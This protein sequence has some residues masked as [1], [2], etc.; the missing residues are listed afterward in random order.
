MSTTPG[1]STTSVSFNLGVRYDKNNG[2][3]SVGQTVIK[4]SAFSPRVSVT[5]DPTG[6]GAWT[7]SA[8]YGKY[9][10]AIANSVGDSQSPGG[11]PATYTY[12]YQGPAINV[13]NPASPTSQD[14]T[15]RQ[16]FAWF[17][18]N[19]GTT[20]PFRAAPTVPGLTGTISD[21]LASP[22]VVEIS[23][24]LSHKLGTRGLVRVD[25]IYR[26]Y[27]DFYGDIINT[28]TGKVTDPN[29]RVFDHDITQNVTDPL[30]RKY[31]AINAQISY[32]AS[33]SLN[34]GANYT[35]SK[36]YGNNVGE[37][38]GSGPVQST[39]LRFPEYFQVSWNAPVG[40][41]ATDQRHR[42]RLFATWDVPIPQSW[43][44]LNIGGL[45]QIASGTPYGAVGTVDTRPFVTNPSATRIRRPP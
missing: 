32:R 17:N 35:L 10:A 21:T 36:N 42:A 39:I 23:G 2:S 6:D 16:I 27:Q 12:N 38:S 44:R 33:T 15:I 31:K 24:G 30:E 25:G 29:G 13:G 22:S 18:A 43:G 20:R 28:T 11:Q 7:M 3:N 45:E 37:T 8:N 41:L 4:D 1:A 40:D 19:G 26:K 5:F 14:D 9:V 34:L